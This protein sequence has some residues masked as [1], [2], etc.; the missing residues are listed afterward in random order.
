MLSKTLLIAAACACL[1]A[2]SPA[3]G[4]S[5]TPVG[6]GTFVKP[7][8]VAAPPGDGRRVLVVEQGGT[9]R[10]VRDGVTLASP[11]LA[12]DTDFTT[13]GERGLLSIAFSPHYESSRL[14]YAFYTDAE[15]DIRV[16]QFRR[17]PDSRDRVER[18]IGGP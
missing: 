10:V 3:A 18:G 5:L 12:L 13:G 17:A 9:V 8:H 1:M 15:G 7:V 2:P 4:Q 16:D 6:G 11:F 14:L